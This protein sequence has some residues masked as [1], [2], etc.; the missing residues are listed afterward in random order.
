M[1]YMYVKKNL[2]PGTGRP[3]IDNILRYQWDAKYLQ[4]AQTE[5]SDLLRT[6]LLFGDADPNKVL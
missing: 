5:Y 3:E 6:E 1:A 2:P 4:K